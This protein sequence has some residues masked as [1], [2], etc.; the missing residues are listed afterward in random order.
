MQ[1]IPNEKINK[2]KQFLKYEDM[3]RSLT[4][5]LLI[6][7]LIVKQKSLRNTEI[8]FDTN[9]FG[10][11]SLKG[12]LLEF[13]LSH[14]GDWVVCAI[15]NSPVGIDI[16]EIKSIDIELAKYIFSNQEYSHFIEKKEDE[17]Q[18]YFFE[19]WT[20]KESYIKAVGSG[21]SFPLHLFSFTKSG[22]KIIFQ[23]NYTSREVYFRQFHIDLNYKLA[24]C[25]TRNLFPEYIH[26]WSFDQLYINSLWL[27]S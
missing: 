8:F 3:L 24:V 22:N 23:S 13:N 12:Y 15:G 10:K 5:E 1:Y 19:L 14:S 7:V 26:I 27:L 16:E 17:R 21:L 9:P 18:S 6:R 20:L 2:L 11:P 4:A 25:N